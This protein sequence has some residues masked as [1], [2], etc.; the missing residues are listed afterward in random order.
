MP[1]IAA[2]FQLGS[3]FLAHQ[4]S[5]V[6]FGFI[7]GTLCFAVFSLADRF[8]PSMVFFGSSVIAATFNFIISNEET[9]AITLIELRFFT[10]FF[11]AGIYP[12]GM[13][14]ASDYSQK[15][16]GKYLGFLVGALVLG[17]AFPHL[18]RSIAD[19]VPWKF[20]I[21]STS[22]LA[23]IGGLAI[24]VFVPDGPFRKQSQRLDLS[25]FVKVFKTKDFRAAAF[26]YFGH[27]WE[28]YSFWVFVP[29]MLLMYKNQHQELEFNI[30]LLSFVIIG[31]GGIACVIAGLISQKADVK[32]L[33][34]VFL[35]SSGVCCLLSPLLLTGNSVILLIAFLIFWG[36]TVVADS[37]MFSTLVAHNAPEEL[38]GTSL[39]IVN[40]IGFSITI[41]SI[42]F[43]N[44]LSKQINANYIYMIL[45]F[46]P[47]LG[48]MALF[49][50]KDT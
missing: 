24:F 14:I 9:T 46:G 16:L 4:T 30:P 33:A 34:G 35:F 23:V 49:N 48:L 40:C 21:Y 6:Q 44:L 1:E 17:T 15:G 10:G 29:V 13:K 36:M 26:G 3:D 7:S 12:V 47:I 45:A 38:R 19:T 18:L 2:D 8:S 11:L 20:V 28:L 25:A 39:T 37:P 41:V 43:M 50:K 32:K 31:S 22:T 42:Q 5:I 27:M